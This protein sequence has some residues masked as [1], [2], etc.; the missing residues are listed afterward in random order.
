MT[1]MVGKTKLQRRR[2]VSGE[3]PIAF[4]GQYSQ[5]QQAVMAVIFRVVKRSGHCRLS[6][7]R[8]GKIAGV[9]VSTVQITL[10]TAKANGHLK[11]DRPHPRGK[12]SIS[13]DL[14]W[15]D[16]AEQLAWLSF[17]ADDA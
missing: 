15:I 6:L 7:E 2:V 16:A 12:V 5:G 1:T 17:E 3:A 8:I 14:G 13:M 10:R 9:S 11:I 4:A